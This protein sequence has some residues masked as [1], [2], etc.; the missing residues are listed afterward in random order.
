MNLVFRLH[1]FT[2]KIPIFVFRAL[3]KLI[4]KNN[5]FLQIIKY[6]LSKIKRS[7]RKVCL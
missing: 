2:L 3:K 4:Y 6:G 1:I 7:E 5:A